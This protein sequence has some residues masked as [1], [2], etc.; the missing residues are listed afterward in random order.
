MT[1]NI[2]AIVAALAVV[3]LLTGLLFTSDRTEPEQ[4]DRNSV[5]FNQQSEVRADSLPI[6]SLRD[7]NSAIVD[8][9]ERMNPTVVTITTR[10]T[11]Q[12][13]QRSPFSYFFNDPRFDQEREFERNG[14]G[15]GVIVS[16]D[17]YILT[18]NHVIAQA[19]EI[20]IR[21]Y[22][23]EEREATVVGADPASD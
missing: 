12:Q 2:Q 9:A 10:Q 4:S 3:T 13:R 17:G 8:I 14:L 21:L 7:F 15:S 1:R 19:D 11:I 5:E 18:N 16:S 6:F 20:N 22:S 23:G